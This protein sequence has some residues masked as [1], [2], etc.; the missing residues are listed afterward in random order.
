MTKEKEMKRKSL[1]AFIWVDLLILIIFSSCSGP[2]RPARFR[3][4]AGPQSADLWQHTSSLPLPTALAS[5]GSTVR[6]E[7]KQ[8]AREEK[9]RDSV[10][11]CRLAKIISKSFWKSK[12]Y[13]NARGKLERRW[14]NITINC[15]L[16]ITRGLSI[17]NYMI[18]VY[19][20]KWWVSITWTDL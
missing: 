20:I 19:E 14:P 17:L 2:A 3:G 10:L 1:Y 16:N 5:F 6:T 11:Y 18:I 4:K 9:R 7:N 12:E 13:K 8:K 15:L